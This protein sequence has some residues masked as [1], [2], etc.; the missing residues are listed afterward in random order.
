MLEG[1]QQRRLPERYE[2][3]WGREF[4]DRI[5]AALRPGVAVLDVGAGRRPTIAIADRPDGIEYVGLDV[6]R[7]ELETAPVGS[8]DEIIAADAHEFVPELAGRFD[9]IV[10]WQVLEHFEDVTRAAD[11]LGAY[12]RPQGQLVAHLSGK[13]AVYALANRMVPDR[14]G[15]RIAAV[16]MR[17][18][19]E[20]V[21]PAHYDRCDADGLVAAFSDWRE[22]EV[23]P[24]WRGADY[25]QRLGPLL[26]VYLR[27]ENWA[28][29]RGM[30]NLATHYTLA[31]RR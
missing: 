1:T 19:P 11:V 6:S 4:W 16:L 27:Y 21:F 5:N 3:E 10:M 12:L 2:W 13:H 15:N 24:F 28:A 30:R 20:T 25:F 22:I 7:E 18:E 29:E 8:Y 31:A 26:D 9:L 17:R 14:L 23:I